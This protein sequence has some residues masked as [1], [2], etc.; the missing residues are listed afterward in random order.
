MRNL[1]LIVV[2]LLSFTTILFSQTL[3]TTQ[4]TK[5]YKTIYQISLGINAIDNSGD[6]SPVSGSWEFNTP[7]SIGI[8]A[9]SYYNKNLAIFGDFT[10]NGYDGLQYY[11]VDT[12]FKY[13]L[14]NWIKSEKFEL[15]PM[16]GIGMFNINRTNVSINFGGSLAYWISDKFALCLKSVAK[17]G[18]NNNVESN[19]INNGHYVHNLGLV[20]ILNK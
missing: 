8:E 4:N 20:Y 12:G 3:N 6:G 5:E 7:L 2:C 17:I 13:Y 15:A 18:L 19:D 11:S 10:Y 14:N 16:A 9:R 1:L